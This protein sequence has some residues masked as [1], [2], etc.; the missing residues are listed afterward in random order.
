ME[1]I[2]SEGNAYRD[3]RLCIGDKILEIDGQDFT[4]KSLAQAMLALSSSTP[5]LRL[6]VYRDTLDE[7]E[8]E[9]ERKGEREREGGGREGGERV[10]EREG[11]GKDGRGK[12]GK[13]EGGGEGGWDAG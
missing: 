12:E 4:Q 1:E 2:F 7:G 9:R 13:R 11:R 5:L 8:G 6:T 10:G 3:G